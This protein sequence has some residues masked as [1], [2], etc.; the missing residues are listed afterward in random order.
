[1][2][3]DHGV[4]AG[5]VEGSPGL[6]GDGNAVEDVATFEGDLGDH[7]D[8]LVV[9]EAGKRVFGLGSGSGCSYKNGG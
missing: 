6:V 1:M 5:G 9:D 3:D 8:G 2:A 4:G 7:G